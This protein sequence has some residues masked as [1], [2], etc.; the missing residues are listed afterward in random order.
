MLLI[1]RDLDIVRSNSRLVLVGVVKTL[2]N[3]QIGNMKRGNVI[4]SGEGV[5]VK[6]TI[7][8]NVS[9]LVK[10][11]AGSSHCKSKHLLNTHRTTSLRAKVEELLD[12]ALIAIGILPEWIDHHTWPR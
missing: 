9:A 7:L 10:S 3:G 12:Y 8:A 4:S 2:D 1:S 6:T 11:L 5:V